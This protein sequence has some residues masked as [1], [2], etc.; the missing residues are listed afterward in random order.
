MFL[1]SCSS[2]CTPCINGRNQWQMK[3]ESDVG[4][5]MLFCFGKNAKFAFVKL[6]GDVL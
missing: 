6:N 3:S 4:W 2:F 1:L 5:T